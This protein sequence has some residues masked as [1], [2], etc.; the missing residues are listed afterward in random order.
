MEY[1]CNICKK[2]YKSYQTLW[3]H[4]KKFHTTNSSHDS[5]NNIKTS[6]STIDIENN[7][8]LICKYCKKIFQNRSN[9]WR[10]ENN[11]KTKI[12]DLDKK[13][14][15]LELKKEEVRLAKEEKQILKLKIQLQKS[16]DIDNI[17]FKKLNK[18]LLKRNNRINYII[19]N[20]QI[21]N[22]LQIINN[23][24]LIGFGK[25]EVYETLTNQ[26]KKLII[27]S[28]YSC[29]EKLIEIVHCGKYDQFKNIVITNIQ[30]NYMYKYDE[31]QGQFILSTKSEI[32]NSLIDY[33]LG[34]LE[35]IYNNLLDKNKLDEKTKEAIEKFIN[36]INY[37]NDKYIDY[38]G[39]EHD[40]YKQYKINEIK[41]LLFN[42][43]DKIT[44]DISLLLTT[45]E[46]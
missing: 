34:D 37:E 46:I 44:N 1:K 35:I 41:I 20:N 38:D 22:N 24:N 25:E 12:N 4:N 11:C 8:S 21:T 33:R 28:K 5:V 39:K 42:N 14:L 40:T 31:K 27:N 23:F 17:T 3:I 9:R 45:D 36:K 19:N 26:E 30:N 7:K 29:L 15:E 32:L 16:N 18:L 2:N 43:Q 13:K 10:H 6:N